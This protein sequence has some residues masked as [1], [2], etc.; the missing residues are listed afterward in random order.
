M[1]SERKLVRSNQTSREFLRNM[2][3]LDEAAEVVC[4]GKEFQNPLIHIKVSA[5][6][7]FLRSR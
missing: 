6:R 7:R 4:V 1:I 3:D 5:L 2:K